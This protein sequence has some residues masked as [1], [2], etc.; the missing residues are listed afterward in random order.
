[1]IFGQG[2][3]PEDGEPERKRALEEEAEEQKH[4]LVHHDVRKIVLLFIFHHV[5]K[6]VI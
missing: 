5:Q 4:R 3:D 1:M 2:R 6:H